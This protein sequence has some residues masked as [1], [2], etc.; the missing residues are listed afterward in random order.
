MT[1]IGIL[2]D[3]HGYLHPK[4]F[5]FFSGV[6]EI[7][8]A[9]DIG[10]LTTALELAAFKPLKGCIWQYRQYRSPDVIS[11]GSTFYN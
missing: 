2:S 10:N 1:H 8:H 9:G 7:W 4:I 3:T 5:E 11:L 6:D